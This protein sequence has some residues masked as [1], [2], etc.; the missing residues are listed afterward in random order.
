MS[1]YVNNV[2]RATKT[3]GLYYDAGTVISSTVGA[4][5]K[6]I[7]AETTVQ[8]PAAITGKSWAKIANVMVKSTKAYDVYYFI[9]NAAGQASDLV[10]IASNQALTTTHRVHQVS[11]APGETIRFA[12]KNLD[13]VATADISVLV[14]LNG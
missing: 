10:A 6:A 4:V 8:A 2:N 14:Q 3:K 1:L 13:A 7:A 12:V 9:T 5:G 11:I